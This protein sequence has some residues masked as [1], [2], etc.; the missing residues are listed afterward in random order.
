MT[1][2]QRQKIRESLEGTV[3]RARERQQ[4]RAQKLSESLA[5]QRNGT[6]RRFERSAYVARR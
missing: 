1:P 6:E 3:E 2:A 5:R 4:Y